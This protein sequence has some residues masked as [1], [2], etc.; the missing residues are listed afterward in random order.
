MLRWLVRLLVRWLNGRLVLSVGRSVGQSVSVCRLVYLFLWFSVR[1]FVGWS[2]GWFVCGLVG[3][4]V[5]CFLGWLV[6][7]FVAVLFCLS[8]LLVYDGNIA[9]LL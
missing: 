5:G 4:M 2:V 7:W 8:C 9:L 3:W 1:H 6:G